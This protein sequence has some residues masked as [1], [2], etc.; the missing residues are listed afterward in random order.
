MHIPTLYTSRYK[1]VYGSLYESLPESQSVGTRPNSQ[2][3]SVESHV[4][5]AVYGS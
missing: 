2:D 4:R 1:Y 5:K 3:L